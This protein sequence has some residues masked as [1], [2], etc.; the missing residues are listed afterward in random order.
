MEILESLHRDPEYE[1][2]EALQGTVRHQAHAMVEIA[3][4][5]LTELMP[6]LYRDSIRAT[7]LTVPPEKT[8]N[9]RQCVRCNAKILERTVKAAKSNANLCLACAKVPREI[10]ASYVKLPELSQY[11]TSIAVW[12]CGACSSIWSCEGIMHSQRK[13][14]SCPACPTAGE[15]QR[16]REYPPHLDWKCIKCYSVWN[17]ISTS[18][19]KGIKLSHCVCC[20]QAV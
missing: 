4:G 12:K 15:T 7:H 8:K 1:R 9:E 6:N 19:R 20:P 10:T 5:R 18:N 2:S 17:A 16:W 3:N 13:L 14:D 11:S